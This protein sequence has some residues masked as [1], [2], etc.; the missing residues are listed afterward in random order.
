MQLVALTDLLA[1]GVPA[2]AAAAAI[3]SL[4]TRRAPAGD[5]AA[6]RAAVARDILAGR[7]P[8]ASVAQRTQV[9]LKGIDS[10]REP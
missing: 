1:R 2:A 6:L 7:P 4:A 5:F 10:R 9:L 8:E 3:D